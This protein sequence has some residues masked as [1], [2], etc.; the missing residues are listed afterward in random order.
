MG[1]IIFEG[2]APYETL[3]AESATAESTLDGVELVLNVAVEGLSSDGLAMLI[4]AMAHGEPHPEL[5]LT[6]T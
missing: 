4:R 1:Q 6:T 2:E 3:E 5:D